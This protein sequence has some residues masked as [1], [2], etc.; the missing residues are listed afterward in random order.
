MVGMCV[1]QKLEVVLE[2]NDLIGH[3]RRNCC[4]TK[5][6]LKLGFETRAR[7]RNGLEASIDWFFA[8]RE[9]AM[10]AHHQ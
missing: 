6:K 1:K 9:L 10:T 8:N 7:P 4:T 3:S 5:L 2:P